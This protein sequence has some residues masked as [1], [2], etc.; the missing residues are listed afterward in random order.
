MREYIESRIDHLRLEVR[1]TNEL[2][3]IALIKAESIMSERLDKLN[4][5]RAL[6]SDQNMKYMSRAEFDII[7]SRLEEDVRMLRES[8]ANLEGNASMSSVYFGYLL[9]VAG[10]AVERG[11]IKLIDKLK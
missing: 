4:G 3:K 8:K 9:S 7:H 1:L 2:N 6:L 10:L 5:Y 11:T